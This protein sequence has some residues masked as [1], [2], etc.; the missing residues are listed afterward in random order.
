MNYVP[1]C[2]KMVQVSIVLLL[3]AGVLKLF[4][5]IDNELQQYSFNKLI[6]Y[7]LFWGSIL[8]LGIFLAPHQR[9][10]EEQ[11][12]GIL[13]A[14]YLTVCTVTDTLIYQ[15]YD[16]MQYPGVL[17][18]LIWVLLKEPQAGL[19]VSVILFAGMQYFILMKKYGKGDGMGYCICSL[20]LAGAGMDIEGY[21]YHMVIGFGLLAAVQGIRGNITGKGNLKKAV[22][23]Y[24]YI[25]AGFLIMWIFLY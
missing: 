3:S 11:V 4:W 13:L 20:Y 12:C 23:L 1:G 24:P 2:V 16:I 7:C 10:I 14:V 8:S 5:K 15:V 21:L 6:K 9:T 19:G 25:S 22:A 17:G 18:G